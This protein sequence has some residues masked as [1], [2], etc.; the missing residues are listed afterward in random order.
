MYVFIEKFIYIFVMI[1]DSTD[2]SK[3]ALKHDCNTAVLDADS[4]CPG[5]INTEIKPDSNVWRLVWTN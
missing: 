2:R 4:W 1:K 3:M 5:D